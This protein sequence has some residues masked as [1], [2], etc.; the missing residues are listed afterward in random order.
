VNPTDWINRRTAPAS[1]RSRERRMRMFADA[2]SAAG[3]HGA[4]ILDAGGTRAYWES[5]AR[6]LP[7]GAVAR[8]DVV[9]LPGQVREL[10]GRTLEIAGV[11]VR[12]V[13]ADLLAGPS[14]ALDARYDVIHCVSVIEHV[15]DAA[16]QRAF[17][18]AL[19]RLGDRLWIQTPA[20]EFP[21]EA[22]FRLPFFAWWPL[23]LRAFFNWRFRLGVMPRHHSWP[24]ALAF[25][26]ATRLLTRRAFARLFPGC[27]LWTERVLGLPKCY[28]ASNL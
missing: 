11:P 16:A 28:V 24:E 8:I 15:G 14:S 4:R 9:N 27:R 10:D 22:H 17:A 13:A 12:F 21:L 25:C 19:R 18:D 2:L 7:P 3:L 6:L 20:K 5:W 23:P 26:R 1:R